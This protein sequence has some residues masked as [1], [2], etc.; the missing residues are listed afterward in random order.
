V[1]V[2]VGGLGA[3]EIDAGHVAQRGRAALADALHEPRHHLLGVAHQAEKLRDEI[4]AAA[5]RGQVHGHLRG[6]GE[7]EVLHRLVDE[8]VQRPVAA[9]GDEVPPALVG[10]ASQGGHDGVDAGRLD[11]APPSAQNLLEAR[12]AAASALV[13]AGVGVDDEANH[14][15]R[16]MATVPPRRKA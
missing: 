16:T 6:A 4:H 5:A 11:D 12:G 13:F 8:P 3:G 9:V 14:G 15:P 7:A 2:A 10:E 1:G